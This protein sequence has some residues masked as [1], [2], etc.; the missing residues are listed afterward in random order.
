M[1]TKITSLLIV[2]SVFLSISS[3]AIAPIPASKQVSNSVATLLTKEIS[4]PEFAENSNIQ[5]TVAVSVVIEND[6]TFS[7][8]AANSD[9][10]QLKNYVVKSI[11]NLKKHSVDYTQFEGQQVLVKFN[12]NLKLD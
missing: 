1:K 8:T 6:G 4:Y 10:D 3:F 2:L 7:V 9:N 11:E 5:G 12:F